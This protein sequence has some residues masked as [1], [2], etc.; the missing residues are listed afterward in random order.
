MVF[1]RRLGKDI[2]PWLFDGAVAAL[3]AVLVS[4][5]HGLPWPIKTCGY[6]MALVL[7]WRRQFPL[8]VLTAVFVLAPAHLLFN[9]YVRLFDLAVLIAMYSVV[10]YHAQLRW[11]VTAGAGAGG[12]VL[13]AAFVENARSGNFWVVLWVVGAVTVATWVTAYGVRTRKLY[14]ESL[15]ER[16]ATLERERDHLSL[17]AVAEERAAIAREV[18]DVVA[19]SLSVMIVQA[20][21]A[22]YT[23]QG[24]QQPARDALATIAATGR[25]ALEDMGR[26]VKLLRGPAP[27]QAAPPT[28]NGPES[29]SRRRVGLAEVDSLVERSGL[30][31]TRETIG[32]GDGLTAAQELTTYRVV[33]E[34]LTNALRHAGADAAVRLRLHFSPCAVTVEVDD[35]GGG[36]S[37]PAASRSSGHGLLG[38]RERVAMH[39]GA[40]V[41]GP[42][43]G[44]GWQVTA[45]IPR[46][47]GGSP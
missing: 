47:P 41:A 22:S 21:A 29:L 36:G 5:E 7:I 25:E 34:S 43:P 39:G 13:V 42:R 24:P 28:P 27:V 16:T 33:Q 18:H 12:A 8:A 10:L 1:V 20:D 15:E 6:L 46:S 4:I 37:T 23:L 17:L 26:V 11:G 9:S 3:V 40:L 35:D 32:S 2:R 45:T 19:H 38:M 31:V 44:G 30:Q 14:V